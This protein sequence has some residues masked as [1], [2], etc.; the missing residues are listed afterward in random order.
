[1]DIR[2]TIS[3]NPRFS[4]MFASITRAGWERTPEWWHAEPRRARRNNPF[5]LFEPFAASAPPREAIPSPVSARL[6]PSS[7]SACISVFC[8]TAERFHLPWLR[9]SRSGKSVVDFRFGNESPGGF[10]YGKAQRRRRGGPRVWRP[11]P[12]G[13]E[14]LTGFGTTEWTIGVRRW[15]RWLRGAGWTVG[16]ARFRSRAF[17]PFFEPR[18]KSRHH[19]AGFPTQAGARRFKAARRTVS[20]KTDSPPAQGG[21]HVRPVGE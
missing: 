12:H 19:R 9:R 20:Q 3:A 4:G 7:G 6:R 17:A 21:S 15:I 18:G 14:A 11:V 5:R 10:R 16:C 1:M 13:T 2:N 8:R